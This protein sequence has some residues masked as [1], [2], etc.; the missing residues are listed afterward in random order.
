[1]LA[2]VPVA[3]QTSFGL[4]LASAVSGDFIRIFPELLEVL[5]EGFLQFLR[6]FIICGRG[7]P[8]VSRVQNFTWYPGYSDR[9]TQAENGIF[10]EGIKCEFSTDGTSYHGACMAE[11]H[12][13]TYAVFTAGP[14][15]VHK[16]Y[17]HFMLINQI[18]EHIRISGG[19]KRQEWRA[20]AC[21]ENRLRRSDASFS[22]CK[23]GS[24]TT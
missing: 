7:F 3:S 20:E 12:T 1:P 10:L 23:L 4:Q 22:S 9:N 8:C 19:M 2:T 18:A 5:Y 6:L 16:V 13:F 15:S 14:S 21:R 11:I 17:I 24:E